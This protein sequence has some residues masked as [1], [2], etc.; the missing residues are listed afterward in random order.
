MKHLRDILFLSGLL[1]LTIAAAGV[2]WR[3]GCA[4]LGGITFALAITSQLHSTKQP[5]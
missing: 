1:L 2:D 4:V 5:K 3:L